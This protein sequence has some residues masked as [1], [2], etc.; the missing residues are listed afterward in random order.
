[1][2]TNGTGDGRTWGYFG[3]FLIA[4]LASAYIFYGFDTAGSLA[5]ETN[6]PRKHAPGAIL[7]AMVAAFVLGALL[8]LFA[9]MAHAEHLR[10]KEIEAIG[11]RLPYIV[12]TVA[13]QRSRRRVPGLL[14]DR[15][16]GVRAR[17]AHGRHPHHVHHGARRPAAV[18]FGGGAG[19]R[20]VADPDRPGDR[21]RR[22]DDRAAAG[23][24]RQPARVLRADLGRDHPVL[25]RLHVRDRP[26]AAAPAARR[27]AAAEPRPVLLARALGAARQHRRGRLPDRRGHQPGLAAAGRVRR[28]A[29]VLPVRRV[30]VHGPVLLVGGVY[31]FTRQHGRT[32]RCWPSTAPPRPP[33]PL[34]APAKAWPD[35]L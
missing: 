25:H 32:A 4:G 8:M 28:R 7:R 17:G 16:H 19:V 24:H 12:K 34:S 3:A 27:V 23:Q 18:R 29:L 6:N 20:Q 35:E 15:D 26:V 10:P 33:A 31:Y 22:A 11:R 14:G 21:H 30:R 1:M 5:E 2:Q 9:M 13:R